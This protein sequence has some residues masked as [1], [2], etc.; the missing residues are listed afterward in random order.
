V[1]VIGYA[2]PAGTTQYDYRD[3]FYAPSLGTLSVP[4]KPTPL[5]NAARTTLTGTVTATAPAGTGR[6]LFGELSV[7]SDQGAT[8]GRA[9]VTIGAVK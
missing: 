1:Q 8:I 6:Q 4:K 5:G 2:V 7:V 3:V 9:T